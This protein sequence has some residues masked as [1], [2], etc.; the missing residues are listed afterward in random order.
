MCSV[1]LW[2][3]NGV[4][5]R[6]RKDS[7]PVRHTPPH[8]CHEVQ[9]NSGRHHISTPAYTAMNRTSTPPPNVRGE[10]ETNHIE[11]AERNPD[12]PLF[13]RCGRNGRACRWIAQYLAYAPFRMDGTSRHSV[14]LCERCAD[15]S[16]ETPSPPLRPWVRDLISGNGYRKSRRNTQPPAVVSPARAVLQVREERTTSVRMRHLTVLALRVRTTIIRRLP[17]PLVGR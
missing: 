11:V 13:L 16:S 10:R 14:S 9:G 8:T 15:L 1:V 7:D 6:S 17:S 3:L 4:N 12:E 5:A 2:H